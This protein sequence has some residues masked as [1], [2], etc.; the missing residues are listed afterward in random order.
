MIQFVGLLEIRRGGVDG[1]F[2]PEY[3]IHLSAS[4]DLLTR[5]C[6][7]KPGL[8]A[9]LPLRVVDANG[10]STLLQVHCEP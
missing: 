5:A 3:R 7:S 10:K 6:A 8:L 1:N 2:S 9:R 4:P